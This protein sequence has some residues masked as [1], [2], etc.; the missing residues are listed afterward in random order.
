MISFGCYVLQVMENDDVL[1][2]VAL[3]GA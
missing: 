1:Q 2:S 3:G